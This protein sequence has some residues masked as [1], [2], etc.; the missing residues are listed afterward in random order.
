MA[1]TDQWG[2][3]FIPFGGKMK[4]KTI[5]IIAAVAVIVVAV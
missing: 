5:Y 1:L 4:K 3:D 2:F